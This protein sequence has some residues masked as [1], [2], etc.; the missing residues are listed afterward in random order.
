MSNF[1]S[2][3]ELRSI[4]KDTILVNNSKENQRM[5]AKELGL[6]CALIMFTHG[7]YHVVEG[8]QALFLCKHNGTIYRFQFSSRNQDKMYIE[9]FKLTF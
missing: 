8:L 7:I 3:E 9:L 6:E 1:N 5:L 2:V 4:P